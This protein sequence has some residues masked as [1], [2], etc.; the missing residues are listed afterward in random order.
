MY[1]TVILFTL[2]GLQLTG[3]AGNGHDCEHAEEELAD[4]S[5]CQ[6]AFESFN[7]NTTTAES[8]VC[9]EPCYKLVK[10]LLEKCD[11]QMVSCIH[12]CKIN[13]ACANALTLHQKFIMIHIY[14]CLVIS[15]LLPC[16]PL[17]SYSCT[18]CKH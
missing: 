8:P 6:E 13:H 11:E 1:F 14:I 3:A 18:Y 7:L 4:N 5:E 12:T 15:S 10:N 16:K 2:L 9:K 17:L